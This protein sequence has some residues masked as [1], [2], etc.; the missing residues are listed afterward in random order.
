M[1]NNYLFR[2]SYPPFLSIFL[3]VLCVTII[4]SVHKKVW[5]GL[6]T[7]KHWVGTVSTNSTLSIFLSQ[8]EY[9]ISWFLVR[10][11]FKSFVEKLIL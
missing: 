10:N 4:L 2:E 3:F 11:G 1:D 6:S 9:S 7:S 5:E 8:I